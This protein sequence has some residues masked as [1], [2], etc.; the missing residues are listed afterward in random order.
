M[1][2]VKADNIAVDIADENKKKNETLT[3]EL[4]FELLKQYAWLSSAVIGV[5]I[6][7]IQLKIVA[8]GEA[9]YVS[10]AS[11]GLSIFFAVI[12]QD[13]IVDSLLKGKDVYQI[14]K[15]LKFIRGT[16]M[17]CLGFGAGYFS[18]TLF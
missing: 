16:S 10:M 11:L 15:M 9:V 13:H 18:I 7:L 17:G 2:T 12:G 5:I 3:T 14:S 1:D 4:H 8:V 6:F